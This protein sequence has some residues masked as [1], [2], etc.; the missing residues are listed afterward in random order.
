LLI[1]IVFEIK[2][3]FDLNIWDLILPIAIAALFVF[4]IDYQRSF[5]LDP[6][7][8]E[9]VRD[10]LRKLG[11][12]PTTDKDKDIFFRRRKLITWHIASLKKG[13]KYLILRS[14]E[15]HGKYFEK[16]KKEDQSV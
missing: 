5:Y 8:E 10:H 13:E 15:N 7:Q 1:G 2:S 9:E 14:S 3:I 6:L 11:Y 12:H 16:K 4:V